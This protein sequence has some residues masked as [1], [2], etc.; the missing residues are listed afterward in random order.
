MDSDGENNSVVSST[1]RI[2]EQKLSLN[3]ISQKLDQISFAVNKITSPLPHLQGSSS[4]SHTALTSHI[5]PRSYTDSPA[6]EAT[7]SDDVSS[8][9]DGDV[10]L[11]TQATFATN[12]LEQVV[13]SNKASN[14]PSEIEKSLDALRK[15][16]TARNAD[17]GDPGLVDTQRVLSPTGQGGY[18]LPPVHL[19]MM[20]I[21]KLRGE[22]VE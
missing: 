9:L 22:S 15:V 13:N 14:Q 20:A 18:Q 3:D 16:L 5:T 2:P 21:Q 11:T 6:E 4:A 19:A 7:P 1:R 10:T 17:N 12:F 8:E